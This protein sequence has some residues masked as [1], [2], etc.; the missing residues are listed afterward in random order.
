MFMI[1]FYP[2]FAKQKQANLME[3]LKLLG[4]CKMIW[5]GPAPLYLP[6]SVGHPTS[7]SWLVSAQDIGQDDDREA[8]R[9]GHLVRGSGT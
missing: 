3:S 4:P 7:I 2:K 8:T 5:P 9:S 1:Q 6:E